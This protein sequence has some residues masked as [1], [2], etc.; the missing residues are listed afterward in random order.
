VHFQ[1][2]SVNMLKNASMLGVSFVIGVPSWSVVLTSFCVDSSTRELCDTSLPLE[3]WSWPLD[4]LC[5]RLPL[6]DQLRSYPRLP[7]QLAS[8]LPEPPRLAMT[9]PRVLVTEMKK[10]L[11]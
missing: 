9:H 2:R 11:F 3:F 6:P 7:G 4:Q 8:R 1:L 10:N 5:S